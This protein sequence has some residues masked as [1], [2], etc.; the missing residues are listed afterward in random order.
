[1][2]ETALS[3]LRKE[4]ERAIFCIEY[5]ETLSVSSIVVL[6]VLRVL[7]CVFCVPPVDA[8]H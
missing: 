5:P 6:V 7:F 3:F 1:M 2:G 4:E 8:L